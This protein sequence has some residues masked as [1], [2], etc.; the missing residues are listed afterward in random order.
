MT[1]ICAPRQTST[2]CAYIPT[3]K[4]GRGQYV[5]KAVQEDGGDMWTDCTNIVKIQVWT[6]TLAGVGSEDL[7][8]GN[9]A[10]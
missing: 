4:A 7:P 3:C 9:T 8:L 10:T 2:E 5:R 6:E 1:L